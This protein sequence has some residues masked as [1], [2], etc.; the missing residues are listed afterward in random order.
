MA[1]H[2]DLYDETD[3]YYFMRALRIDSKEKGLTSLGE[4]LLG[5]QQ[6]LL[7]KMREGM[8]EGVREFVT[9]KARQLGISTITL[10]MDLY[11]VFNHQ[12]LPAAIVTQ[13]EAAREGFRTTL[14]LYRSGLPEEYTREALDDNRNQTVFDNGSR[15]RFLVAGTRARASGSSNLGRSGALVLCHATEVA[16]WGDA[17]GV[18]ALRASFAHTNPHRLYHW[19]STANGDGN[20]FKD[21]WD[22]AKKSKAVAANFVSWW[23]NDYYGLF[24]DQRLFNHYWG[25][26]GRMTRDEERITREVA[27][28]YGY[29]INEY[30]WAWYRYM[31]AEKITD[32]A[33]MAQEFPHLEEHAFIATGSAFFSPTSLTEARREAHTY[34]KG[35]TYFR[36][37]C[38]RSFAETRVVGCP[39]TRANLTVWEQPSDEGWYVLG[40]DPAYASGPNANLSAIHVSRTWYNRMEQVAEFADNSISTHAVA[41]VMSYLAGYYARSTLNVEVT[42]PGS[43]VLQEF[44]N[45][46]RQAFSGWDGDKPAAMREVVMRIRQYLYRRPDSTTGATTFKH[47][48]ATLDVAELMMNSLRDYLERGAFVPKSEAMLDEM[49]VIRRDQGGVP[50]APQH[51]QDDRTKAAALACMCWDQQM[52]AQLLAQGVIWKESA[53]RKAGE[54]KNVVQNVVDRYLV[55]VGIQPAGG[56]PPPRKKLGKGQ[57][58]WDGDL[59]RRLDR[60]EN[61]RSS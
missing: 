14:A 11:W 46:R 43:A 6:Y 30:Q 3:F 54:P 32:E 59:R 20:W 58:R 10:A 22:D 45:L 49:Q 13:D 15:I 19:E 5:S 23:A 24:H 9:L 40:V 12:A 21:M 26:N 33:Q 25:Q 34:R 31:A 8:Q 55:K 28:R 36:V 44:N 1:A 52:R 27:R 4:C 7:D 51:K 48:K 16:F 18:D 50:E 41:W 53:P 39:A 37:E 56:P 61:G 42:G 17:S 60:A 2:S 38:G 29:Q 47:T 35:A 57:R